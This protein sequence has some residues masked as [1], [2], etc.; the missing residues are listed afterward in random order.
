MDTPK[1]YI[2]LSII[3][4]SSLQTEAPL[5]PFHFAPPLFNSLNKGIAK[6]K[7]TNIL[8]LIDTREKTEEDKGKEKGDKA[9]QSTQNKFH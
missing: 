9:A 2:L 8:D 4:C 6:R 3:K 5:I 1:K 7:P